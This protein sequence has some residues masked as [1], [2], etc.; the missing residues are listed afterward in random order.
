MHMRTIGTK[1]W[2]FIAP[3]LIIAALVLFGFV[4]MWLWNALMPV[5]F[6]LPVISYWQAVGLILL[7]RIFF[8]GH[9]WHRGGSKFRNRMMDRWEKMTP[10]ER[11][12]FRK[13]WPHRH[14]WEHC[15]SDEKHGQPEGQ[16]T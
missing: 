8:G 5:I 7:S 16:T 13:Q 3:P 10:E 6:H 15:C 4:T 14:H 2:Y 12:Q 1:K 11:E 9:H